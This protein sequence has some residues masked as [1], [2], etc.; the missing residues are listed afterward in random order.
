[1]I[2]FLILPVLLG[3][4][5]GAVYVLPERGKV[6][7][8]AIRM[9]LPLTLGEWR[10]KKVAVSQHE[11]DILDPHTKF[12]KADYF[13]SRSVLPLPGGYRDFDRI[14]V[15]VVLS[16][17]DIN[18][19]IHRP[20]RCLPAQ[21]H[22]I[23]SSTDLVIDLPNGRKLPMRCLRTK[24]R[25]RLR[26]DSDEIVVVD[27]LLFYFFVG[28]DRVTNDHYARTFID[29]RDRIFKGQDQRWAYVTLATTTGEVPW[30]PRNV[31]PKEAET[32]LTEFCKQLAMRVID[33]DQVK[34]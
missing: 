13:R 19:S 34:K 11:L 28:H 9:D 30:S 6:A 21:G 5:L 32:M 26:E 2:R 3:V 25:I 31:S 4:L 7:E 20:E 33:W 23:Y 24:Q 22:T 12:A 1:V 17:Y 18:N 10:G 29:M 16:G 27:S 14:N 8:S 15:S